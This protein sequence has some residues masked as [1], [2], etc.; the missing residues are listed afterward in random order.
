M[1]GHTPSVLA[2]VPSGSSVSRVDADLIDQYGELDRQVQQF[3]PIADKHAKLK[4]VIKSWYDDQPGEA[5]A[6]AAGRLY[7]VQVSAR[8]NERTWSSMA[9]V[10]R[11]VGGCTAFL[12]ICS[13]AIKAVEEA[14][15]KSKAEALLVEER[16]GSRRLKVVAKAAPQVQ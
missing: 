14:I 13:V 4:A 16:T 5:S 10:Y 12:K 15:G 2:I 1:V 8:E 3:K 9:K 7:E 11:A 6:I